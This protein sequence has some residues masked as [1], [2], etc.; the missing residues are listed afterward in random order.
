MTQQQQHGGK[1][2]TKQQQAKKDKKQ[3]QSRE[4]NDKSATTP[5]VNKQPAIPPS[6]PQTTNN[7]NYG[8]GRSITVVHIAEKPSIG[9]AIAQGLSG[10]TS[11]KSYGKSLPVHEFSTTS[12]KFPKA[13]HASSVTHSITSVAG[14]VYSV[15]FPSEYASWDS[16]DPAEKKPCKGS[17][18]KHLQDV[19]KGVD[20]IVLWMVRSIYFRT[21]VFV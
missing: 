11:T 2:S 8:S 13:P 14:H 12:Q 9:Q 7:L 15:D 17:V 5:K 20:F 6:Q 10:S 3:Q 18:V 16:V 19:T 4:K 21:K 1:S